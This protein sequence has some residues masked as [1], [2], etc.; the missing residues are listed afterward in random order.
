MITMRKIITLS[1]IVYL[2]I[3]S[4]IAYSDNNLPASHLET[5]NLQLKWFNQFQFA[6][7]Y[8]AKQQGFYADEGLDVQIHE[9]SPGINVIEQ[10]I[11]GDADYGIGDSGILAEYANGKPIKAL[12]AIFQHDPLVFISKQSS[13]I[14][15]PYEMIGKRIMFDLE[16]GDNSPL[17]TMLAHAGI[18]PQDYN[19][20]PAT[21]K[22]DDLLTDK[23][24]V[25]FA[26]LTDQPF[27]FQQ[28]NIPLNIINPQN[29]GIDF[30]GDILFTSQAELKQHP[31]RAERFRRASLKGWKYALAHTNEII[32]LIHNDYHSKLSLAHLQFEAEQ[33]RKLILADVV[34]LGKIEVNRLRR[35][36]DS[37]FQLKM[38]KLL[39]EKELNEFIY[40]DVSNLNLSEEER[41]WLSHHPV[42]R[43]GID[44]NF[45][46][47]EWLN[48]KGEYVGLIADYMNLIEDRL[49]VHF[50]IIKDK[51]WSEILELAK[52]DE[53]DVIAD[54][55]KTPERSTYLD[56]SAPYISTPTI[57]INENN[58]GYIG[59]LA[60]L[61]GKRVAV[62][63]GYFLQELLST[64]YPNIQLHTATSV[65]NA[66]QL[67][68]EGKADAYVGDAASANHALKSAGFLNLQFSGQTDY[69][70]EH[71]IAIVKSKPELA[72]IMEKTLASITPEQRDTILHRWMDLKIEPG[73]SSRTI[74]Q[75]SL[76]VVT[77]FLLFSYWI[78]R[79]QK[80]EKS[81][82]DSE[83]RLQTI[84]DY[85]PMGI[86]MTDPSGHFRFVNKT[87]CDAIGISEQQF[88]NCNNF[89]ALVGQ[90][91]ADNFQQSD[92]R[93]LTNHKPYV[94]H[95]NL[96]LVDGKM[97]LMEITKT[98]L[99]ENLHANPHKVSGIIGIAID[100]TERRLAEQRNQ[101]HQEV[102]ALLAKNTP[103]KNILES[104][105]RA[106]EQENP[107]FICSILLADNSGKHLL[108]GASPS[109][110]EFYI[111]AIHGLAIG[112]NVGS[113][114]TAA[115]TR[116]RVIV[117]DIQNHPD[118][119][120]YKHLASQANLAA[121]WSEP[122]LAD[123]FRLLGTFA[124]Y[125]RRPHTPAQK[126]LQLI[127]HVTHLARIAIER[128]QSQE[129]L[130]LASL[131]F[132]HTSEAMIV[133]DAQNIII[134]I[135]PAVTIIT[136]YSTDELLGQKPSLLKSDRQSKAFYQ[137]MWQNLDS[138]GRWQ[139]EIWNKRKNGEEYLEWLTINTIFGNDGNIK[140][141]VALFSDVSEKKKADEKI[142]RQANY[143]TLT[144]LPNRNMFTDRLNHEIKL[145]ERNKLLLAI[146]FLDLDRFKEINDNFGHDQGDLLLIEAARRISECVRD[147]DIVARLGGDEFTVLLSNLKDL[148][149]IE[150]I[151]QHII[152][153]LNKPFELKSGLGY[154]SVSIGIA[155]YPDDADDFNSLIKHADQAMY[156]AKNSG[157]NCFV[158]FTKSMQ[159]LTQ[160]RHNLLR[161]LRTAV[162]KQ[163][164]ELYYQPIVDL[165]TEEIYKAEALIRWNHPSRG[166]VSPQDF[167]PIAEESGLINEI[168]DWVF[169]Q[170]VLMVKHCQQQYREDFQISIN[171]SPV[172]FR[173][174]KNHQH[175]LDFLNQ[176]EI[177]GKSII[178][179]I[180]EGLLM[181]TEDKIIQQLLQFRDAGIQVAIDDF[182]TGYS[183]LSYSF[184]DK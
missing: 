18:T 77:I 145:A 17:I 165:N 58:Q 136:G 64:H 59:A 33:A 25:M 138:F 35:V 69:P 169:K 181:D 124:I 105:V 85:S 157:R 56:F 41:N 99:H 32:Q 34:P 88:L 148:Q 92:Q 94:S 135:N 160:Y 80:A 54:A 36:A 106:V 22:I 161:D 139:G 5:V 91:I 122:I 1:F 163:Q 156:Y 86:W 73:L 51:P 19:F 89:S 84:L 83:N 30:Y 45:P 154:V 23:V 127:E 100:I 29:Y 137:N 20:V 47:Y 27:F 143:D 6:G 38:S 171:K 149:C 37:Y 81:L 150:R 183:A 177:N 125:H 70:S 129:S 2:H 60:H 153:I 140:Q 10:V 123:A 111:R 95:E 72:S 178:V 74:I 176:T 97:H 131:V 3:I 4:T 164:F 101:A 98:C 90:E 49:G 175:W 109:L 53:L 76:G 82:Q 174:T 11:A 172:Q 78:Y 65:Q 130:Q 167:I 132:Q 184:S 173:S 39:S 112:E 133:T 21:F 63:Q 134:A 114:G 16:G 116:Q 7:Y 14:I 55:V 120:S 24:D 152:D 8:A 68:V 144:Q 118:W 158:Y 155:F 44:H 43:L 180:T 159:E 15:S 61:N 93:C 96:R 121:C 162:G 107:D 110:P 126:D 113:C 52:H 166:M 146:L 119:V 103:L 151:A 50:E 87:F 75:I 104:I 31:G 102:L 42:I 141:Y 128:H 28:K 168:G 62:E 9:L 57:I 179:E 12:A 170:A 48:N 26:Y 79:L 40:A 66:L 182:G 142:W 46:P 108:D 71:R 117:S 13:G 115:F 147:E 67:V